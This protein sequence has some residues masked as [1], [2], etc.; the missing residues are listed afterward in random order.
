VW[1][2]P[3]KKGERAT[4]IEANIAAFMGGRGPDERY[5]SFDYCFN[6]FQVFREQDRVKEIAALE[7]MQLSCLHLGFYLA[8]WGMFRGSSTLLLKSLKH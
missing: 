4:D 1:R 3:G 5:T 8:S 7:S 2:A 6:Y